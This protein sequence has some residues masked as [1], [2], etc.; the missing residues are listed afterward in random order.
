MEAREYQAHFELEERHWWFRSRRR[1]AFR[2]LGRAL[3]RDGSPRILDAGCGTGINL[4]GMAR[5]GRVSGCDFATEALAFCRQRGLD[6]LVRADVNRLP[7]REDAFDLVTFFDVL[8]HQAVTDDA[9]VLRDAFHILKPG[10]YVLIM[11]SAFDFLRGP[12]DAAMHGARRY[13]R[14]E[15]VAKCEAAGLQ[16]VHA[17]YFYMTTFPAVYLKRRVERRRAARHPEMETRSD[18]AP[19]ARPINAVLGGLL[20]LEGRWASRRRLPFGSSVVVLARKPKLT[21]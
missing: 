10:G 12:H 9:A 1:L 19:T 7:Y 3:P 8:Y 17:T 14:R 13:T 6:G 11:D 16:P 15:L 20:G 2:I 18:L 21:S 5:F 4:A